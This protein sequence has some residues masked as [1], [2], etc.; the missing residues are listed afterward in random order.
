MV[1]N[2]LCSRFRIMNI[3]D[4]KYTY[5]YSHSLPVQALWNNVGVGQVYQALAAARE[6]QQRLLQG[7]L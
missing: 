3:T 2:D 7:Q 6:K 5:Y 4:T 1:L